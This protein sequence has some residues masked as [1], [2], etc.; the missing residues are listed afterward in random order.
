MVDRAEQEGVE[1]VASFHFLVDGWRQG[2]FTGLA[3]VNSY[4]LCRV[5]N[6]DADQ[7]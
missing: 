2:E 1:D 4:K 3:D 5:G 6:V 7:L